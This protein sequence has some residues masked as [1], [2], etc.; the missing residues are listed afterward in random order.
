[1]LNCSQKLLVLYL[2]AIWF[3]TSCGYLTS[4][5]STS[6]LF[7]LPPIIGYIGGIAVRSS[8]NPYAKGHAHHHSHDF[9]HDL[10]SSNEHHHNHPL[11]IAELNKSIGCSLCNSPHYFDQEHNGLFSDQHSSISSGIGGTLIQSD[12]ELMHHHHTGGHHLGIFD[13]PNPNGALSTPDKSS[14]YTPMRKERNVARVYANVNVHMPKNYYDYENFRLKWSSPDA[15]EIANKIG[16]GKYSEVFFGFDTTN[17]D[18]EVVIKIL[19]PIQKHKI[20]REIKILENLHGGPNIIPLLDTIRDPISKTK[21]L[22]FP[23]VNKTDVRELINYLKDGDLIYYMYE[24]LKA[25][26]YTHSK[27]IMHRDIKPHNIAIDH[28]NR[29]LYLLDWGLAEFY[30]PSKTYNIKV[31]S[32]HYKPPEL[33]VNMYDYDYSLDM[34]S[35]GCLFAGLILN[36]DPFFNGENNDDQMVKIVK[37]LGTEDF[38]KYLDKYGLDVDENLMHKIKPSTKK[39]WEQFIPFENDDIAHPVAIDF[40]DKLL[41]YDP[42]ERLTAKEA[43]NHPY[44]SSAHHFFG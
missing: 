13:Q 38:Y 4:A 18:R 26:D 11:N 39:N 42:Q 16:R 30:H 12:S 3:V 31:A 7:A 21:S 34:W 41:R 44:F 8:L 36:R 43:M 6:Y 29:K 20:Q 35:L 37:V 23:F 40:L 33:L 28:R 32:R 19:K 27:G 22:V 5:L 1:M 10:S 14:N 25:I 15:Y 2:I 9:E 17:D 24:L